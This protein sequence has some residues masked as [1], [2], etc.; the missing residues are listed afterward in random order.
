MPPS[1]RTRTPT[2]GPSSQ[3]QSSTTAATE[4][5]TSTESRGAFSQYVRGVQGEGAARR[6]AQ[7]DPRGPGVSGPDGVK[8][9]SSAAGARLGKAQAAVEHAK[10]VFA[11]GAGNQAEAL[12]A[13]QFNSYF[14]LKCM[15]DP[16]CW[17][18]TS[19]VRGLAAANPEALTAAKADLAQGGNCGEHAQVAFDY[20]RVHA[21]GQ[22]INRSAK[23]GLDHAFVLIGD[24]SKEDDSAIVV[25][26]PWP[27]KATACVWQDHFAFTA[28]RAQIDTS[29]S[30]TADGSNIK[31][32]IAAGLK[33]SSR[34]LKMVQMNLPAEETDK[35]VQEGLGGWVWQHEQAQGGGRDHSYRVDPAE[36][37]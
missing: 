15:R 14:R 8:K 9:V 16:S 33:L 32:V 27:T 34:G 5:T 24:L 6:Q 35:K 18:L 30:M 23:T 29:S 4:T 31:A 2:P 13:T 28:D 26:D 22:V 17:E 7:T 19:S 21:S 12:K 3:T 11:F 1:P 10:A 20:L 36:G 25:S 37:R